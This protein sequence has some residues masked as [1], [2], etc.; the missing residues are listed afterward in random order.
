MET[1]K[2]EFADAIEDEY[3][4]EMFIDDL[5]MYGY[6]GEVG[7]GW[8]PSALGENLSSDL[9]IYLSTST[10]PEGQAPLLG[11][12]FEGSHTYLY[13]HLH[14]S[15]GYNEDQ[16]VSVNV[17]TLYQRKIDILAPEV[18]E[19][20]SLYVSCCMGVESTDQHLAHL[21]FRLSSPIP[22]NGSKSPNSNGK[23][24][25]CVTSIVASSRPHLR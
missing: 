18:T 12:T 25:C 7:K 6:I 4:F 16:V 8:F 22:W 21:F 9:S 14:F 3:Y 19:V 17:T 15:I 1:Q 5:P 11:H 10:Q 2:R 20:S 24:V 23:I 13:P